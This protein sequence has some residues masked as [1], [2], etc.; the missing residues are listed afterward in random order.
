MG[1]TIRDA[2]SLTLADYD[3]LMIGWNEVHETNDVEPPDPDV[4][5]RNRESPLRH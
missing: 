5:K 1:Y 4:W 3:A 2:H